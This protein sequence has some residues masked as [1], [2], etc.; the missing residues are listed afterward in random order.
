MAIHAWPDQAVMQTLKVGQKVPWVLVGTGTAN[1]RR[2]VLDQPAGGQ[3]R[4]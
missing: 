1:A 3:T 4:A 2:P